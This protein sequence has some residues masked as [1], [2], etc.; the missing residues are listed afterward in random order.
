VPGSNH[1]AS[2]TKGYKYAEDEIN[3]LFGKVAKFIKKEP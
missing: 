1:I 3:D 2:N